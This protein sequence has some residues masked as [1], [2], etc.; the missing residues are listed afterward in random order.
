M[1]A[2][3]VDFQAKGLLVQT[4]VVPVTEFGRAQRFN[5]NDGWDHDNEAF[6]C[7]LAG[8]G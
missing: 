8:V 4:R 2:V 7:L 6:T 1:I 5:D 3:L